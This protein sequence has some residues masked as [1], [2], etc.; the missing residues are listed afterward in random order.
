MRFILVAT[1]A[2]LGAC[3]HG[4]G[5]L[6]PDRSA[7][8]SL[9]RRAIWYLDPANE[10]GSLDSAVILLDRYLAAGG[11]RD[12]VAEAIAFRR[13]IDEALELERVEVVLHQSLAAAIEQQRAEDSTKTEAPPRREQPRRVEGPHPR[14][15]AEAAREIQRLREA[16]RDANAELERIRKRLAAPPPAKP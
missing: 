8:E 5:F 1:C 14:P 10:R 11:K 9:Y 3:A 16:L 2:V 12:R 4:P 6:R 7:D 15:S 13:L